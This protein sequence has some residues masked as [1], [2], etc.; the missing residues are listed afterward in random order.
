MRAVQWII[1]RRFECGCR[2]DGVEFAGKHGK[3]QQ[4]NEDGQE[5][6]GKDDPASQGLPRS[7]LCSAKLAAGS[8]ELNRD[9][10]PPRF[11]RATTVS[12]LKM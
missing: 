2:D 7:A 11:A 12:M 9:E 3:P 5:D 8:V 10:S 6:D 4:E 1:A